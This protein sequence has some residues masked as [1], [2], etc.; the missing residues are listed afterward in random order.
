[1]AKKPVFKESD[2]PTTPAAVVATPEVETIYK[3]R[4]GRLGKEVILGRAIPAIEDGLLPVARRSLYSFYEQGDLTKYKKA[5]L[6]V[7]AT[8]GK[9]HAHGDASVYD[10]MVNL[11]QWFKKLNPLLESEGN[12]GNING[13][14]AAAMRYLELR[15]S[16]ASQDFFFKD[17][18]KSIVDMQ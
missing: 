4:M 14:P 8:L 3:E 2:Y 10:A 1:M 13:D 6:F 9:Y 15:M 11:S 12:N 5:A 18:D 17:F 7:G 16:K